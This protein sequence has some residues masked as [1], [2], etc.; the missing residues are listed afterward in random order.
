MMCMFVYKNKICKL[1]QPGS[2][3]PLFDI[4]RSNKAFTITPITSNN[5]DINDNNTRHNYIR[6]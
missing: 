4:T 1:T 5:K 6:I 2:L 3:P